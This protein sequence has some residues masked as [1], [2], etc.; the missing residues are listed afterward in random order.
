MTTTSP[1]PVK[2]RALRAFLVKGKRVEIGKEIEVSKAFAVELV[3]V[4]K[5]EFVRDP[6]AASSAR[7]APPAPASKA[8]AAASAPP[9]PEGS[10]T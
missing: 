1:P 2:V 10:Q 7:Q 5:A 3:S 9:K 8:P 6:A 4:N